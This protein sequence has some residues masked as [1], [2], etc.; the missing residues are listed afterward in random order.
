MFTPFLVVTMGAGAPVTL[1][2]LGLAYFSNLQRVAHALRHD[3]APIYFG[4]S[5]VT[6]REW[7]GIGFRVSLLTIS[8]M[9]RA[10]VLRGG[11]FW[12]GGELR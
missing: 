5:Y 11:R 7:W 9:G 6:Q 4:A 12:A 1:A 10:W 8:L 3:T 2:V